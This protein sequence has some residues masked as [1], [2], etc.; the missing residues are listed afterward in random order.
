M[1]EQTVFSFAENTVCSFL[2][3]PIGLVRK[4][5]VKFLLSKVKSM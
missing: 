1:T 4:F 3:S 5:R 2:L